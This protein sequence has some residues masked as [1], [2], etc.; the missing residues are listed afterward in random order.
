VQGVFA[1]ATELA[2]LVRQLSGFADDPTDRQIE[3]CATYVKVELEAWNDRARIDEEHPPYDELVRALVALHGKCRDLREALSRFSEEP[4][5]IT[6]EE[7]L[8]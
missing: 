3:T 8:R 7:D 2:G 4:K 6:V 1:S 5:I